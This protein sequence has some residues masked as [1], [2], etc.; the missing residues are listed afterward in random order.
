VGPKGLA[1]GQVELKRRSDGTRE[2]LSPEDA[3]IRLTQ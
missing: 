3:I 2:L 1:A